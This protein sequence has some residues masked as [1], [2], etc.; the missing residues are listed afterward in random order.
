MEIFLPG[1][2]KY[3]NLPRKRA[4]IDLVSFVH[5]HGYA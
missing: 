3:T 5:M 4:R 1:M 2:K